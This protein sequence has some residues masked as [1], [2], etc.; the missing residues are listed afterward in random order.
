MF[1]VSK[2]ALSTIL[3][4]A[5]CDVDVIHSGGTPCSGAAVP[6]PNSK[7][8]IGLQSFVEE[9]GCDICIATDGDADRLGIIDDRGEFLHPN[10]NPGAAVLL[11][12]AL[13]GLARGGGAQHR[14][15]PP[16][17][18]HRGGVRRDLLRGAGG[19]QVRVGQ[20]GGNRGR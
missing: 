17:G 18:R 7:T 5:R 19:L 2:T 4:T 11:P 8:L 12:A 15:H 20:D 3:I 16:A 1:G 10:K 6:A 9:N 14:H 13:Q